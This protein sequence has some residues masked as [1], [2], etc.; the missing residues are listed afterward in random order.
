[1]KKAQEN[2]VSIP[3]EILL[4]PERLNN[5]EA[6]LKVLGENTI[7]RVSIKKEPEPFNPSQGDICLGLWKDGRFYGAK[8]EEILK[9]GRYKV[10]WNEGNGLFIT[11]TIKA[12]TKATVS[13]YNRRQEVEA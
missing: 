12:P 3:K 8:I 5:I 4:I 6:L 1:M 2:S 11:D 9:D 7:R 13:A 10:R